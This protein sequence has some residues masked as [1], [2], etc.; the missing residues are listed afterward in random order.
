MVLLLRVHCN[1]GVP[2]LE[3]EL[4]LELDE[5][6]L[7]DDELELDVL[8]PLDTPPLL[9]RPLDELLLELLEPATVPL[10]VDVVLDEL[11]LV[12]PVLDELLLAELLLDE[13]LLDELLVED[14]LL[15]D[16]LLEDPPELLGGLEDFE[17]QAT[18]ASRQRYK[19][20]RNTG[21]DSEAGQCPKALTKS[22]ALAGA[23][24]LR[25]RGI[26]LPDQHFAA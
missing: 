7:D 19:Q 5:L 15:D 13:L 1:W 20:G 8:P 21:A 18:R 26:C 22:Y 12:E 24:A 16:E 3:L 25:P 9:L 17:P 6:E 23:F 11:L 4:E 14:E 2:L 10:L